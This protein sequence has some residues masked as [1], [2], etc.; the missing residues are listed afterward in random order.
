MAKQSTPTNCS[1]PRTFS[2]AYLRIVTVAREGKRAVSEH[3]VQAVWYDRLFDR[4]ALRTSEGQRVRVVSPGWWN[5]AEGPDFRGAQI[6]FGDT[7]RTG[8]IEV[9]LDHAAWRAHGHHLDPRYDNV[10]LVVVLEPRPPASLPLTSSGRA[11]PCLLLGNYVDDAIY[12]L[13]E[14]AESGDGE[15]DASLGR[16]YCAAIAQAHGAGRVAEF[17][18]LAGEWRMLNKARAVRER[19]ERVGVDQAVYEAFMAA[20]GYSRYKHHFR[21]VAQQLPYERVV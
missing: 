12:N 17:A 1:E 16:G 9:H 13:P 18:S 10:L 19:M 11:I 15:A 4:E 2:D 5:H 3:L 8:D 6:A 20:C 7:T 14:L 21:A